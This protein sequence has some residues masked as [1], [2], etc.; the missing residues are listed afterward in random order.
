MSDNEDNNESQTKI[1]DN[2]TRN[3]KTIDKNGN[4]IKEET[5][6]A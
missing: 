4:I 6:E 1:A 5:K 2:L 3:R